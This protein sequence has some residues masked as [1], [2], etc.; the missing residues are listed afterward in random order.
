LLEVLVSRSQRTGR[1]NRRILPLETLESRRYLTTAISFANHVDFAA[2]TAPTAIVAGDFNNDGKMDLAVA[3]NV[4]KD[5]EIFY[6]NGDGTFSAGPILTV[7]APPVSLVTGDF[8]GDGNL[9]L[10]V[11]CSPGTTNSGTT[12]TVF[13]NNGSGNFGVGLSTTVALGGTPTDTIALASADFN[14]DGRSDIAATVLSGNVAILLSNANGTFQT[15]VLYS[16]N[17]N[18]D[19][20]AALNFGDGQAGL[21]V[22]GS[23]VDTNNNTSID[24]VSL[25]R[26]LGNGTFSGDGDIALSAPSSSAIT[27]GDV[28]GDGKADIIVGNDDG[29]ASVLLNNGNMAFA[30]SSTVPLSSASTGIAVADFNLG[31]PLDIVSADGSST[32]SVSANSITTVLGVGDGTFAGSTDFAT[33]NSP[34]GLVVADFNGDG[35]P[36]VATVSPTA[37]TVSILLN[38]TTEALQA[39]TTKIAVDTNPAVFGSDVNF[40]ATVTGPSGSLSA[41]GNVK[42]FDGSALIGEA[43]IVPGTGQATLTLSSLGVGNHRISAQYLGSIAFNTSKSAAFTQTITPTATN[44]PDL[45]GTVMATSLPTEFVAGETA[46][47]KIKVTNQGDFAGVGNI[48][49]TLFLSLDQTIDSSDIP[50]TIHGSLAKAH[51]DLLPNH[52]IVLAAAFKVP[53]GVPQAGYFLLS[54]LN[55]TG[56]L[57]ESN[58]TNNTVVSSATYASVNDFGNV[59]GRR[60]VPLMLTNP[61]V[62]Y[63]LAGPGTGSVSI[64]DN[65]IDVSLTGTT[66]ASSLII[67]GQKNAIVNLHSISAT[68]ALGSIVAPKVDVSQALT[69]PNS[70]RA[71]TLDALLAGSSVTIGAGMPTSLKVGDLSNVT[72]SSGAGIKSLAVTSSVAPNTQI[73]AP[74]IGSLAAKQE[75]DASMNLSGGAPGGMT[76]RSATIGGNITSSVWA[77]VGNVGSVVAKSIAVPLGGAIPFSANIS[78]KLQSFS[79]GGDFDANMAA[80]N[81]GTVSIRGN[82]TGAILAGTNFGPNDQIGGD[83]DT[84][85]AGT[86]TSLHIVGSVT[87][88]LIAAGLSPVDD[89]SAATLVNAADTFAGGAIKALSIGKTADASSKFLA[90]ALPKKVRIGAAAVTPSG[91]TRFA[92]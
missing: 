30:L 73:I 71:I 8:N 63:R 4:A 83:D 75:F 46:N 45:V 61:N 60:G 42:F 90:V 67:T 58:T 19:A 6:G 80:A 65:G 18:P 32:E 34:T 88:S 89:T 69:L 35:K 55:T 3:D 72:L 11:G 12:V 14:D 47:V 24:R 2:G 68:S 16:V 76:L 21:A 1:K 81:F 38:N 57:L 36:D 40:T 39:T 15:P 17:T 52:S 29:T 79:D 66:A 33:G 74:W 59:G 85:A 92:V 51:V 84:F 48:I 91:D 41:T 82:M 20:I 62:T 10:A 23:T 49:N 56:S 77:I 27:F 31:G 78:G 9:D 7:T 54:G 70:A 13:L 37:G 5:V 25:L 53:A 86:I 43:S 44:G 87:S 50:L 28:N 64:G 26:G 22:V